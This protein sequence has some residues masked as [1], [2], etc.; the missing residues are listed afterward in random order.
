MSADGDSVTNGLQYVTSQK[1]VSRSSPKLTEVHCRIVANLPEEVHWLCEKVE[2]GPGGKVIEC[3]E[4][5][6]TRQESTLHA[7]MLLS[8]V[9]QETNQIWLKERVAAQLAR[10]AQCVAQFYSLKRKFYHQLLK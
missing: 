3:N 1:R 4:D 9:D 10:C 7:L 6:A 5:E 2:P 8:F